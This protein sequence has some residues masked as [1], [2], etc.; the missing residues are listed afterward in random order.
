[1]A[2]TQLEAG[3]F[4]VYYSKNPATNEND[5]PRLAIRMQ[6]NRIEEVRGITESQGIDNYIG[7]VLEKKLK[8]F[9][10]GENYKERLGDMKK[11]T[12]IYNK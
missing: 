10:D 3:D 2:N 8:D 7:P 9:S 4:Y 12:E 11:M 6:G 1:M 5:I